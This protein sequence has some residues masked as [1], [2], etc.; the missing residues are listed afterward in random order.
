VTIRLTQTRTYAH[1]DLRYNERPLWRLCHSINAHLNEVRMSVPGPLNQK[2]LTRAGIAGAVLAVI[3]IAIFA[4]LWI[5]LGHA[6]VDV[7]PRLVSSICVPPL[8]I[9]LLVGGYYLI[10]RANTR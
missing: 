6:G 9:G 2:G 7:F 10:S 8:V 3:G 5:A 1:E 4:V